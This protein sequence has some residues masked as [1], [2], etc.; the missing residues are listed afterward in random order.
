[1]HT[2]TWFMLRYTAPGREP[3]PIAVLLFDPERDVLSFR[4]LEN[5]NHFSED[6][7]DYLESLAD[8]ISAMVVDF[9]ATK[10]LEYLQSTL[11]NVLLISD[12]ETVEALDPDLELDRL[13]SLHVRT[14]L[15]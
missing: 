13:F 15:Q 3:E 6:D 14:Q 5:F 9:G 2:L 12:G 4:F 10:L 11:S 7:L 1:M 8:G